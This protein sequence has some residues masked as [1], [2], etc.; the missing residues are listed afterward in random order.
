MDKE[1][2]Q[3]A[4]MNTLE[5]ETRCFFARDYACWQSYFI[6]EEYAFQAW[7]NADG[8][9]SAGVGWKA[10]DSTAGQ[11]IRDNPVGE[12]GSSHPVVKRRDMKFHFF[13]PT[14]A[15]LTWDQYNADPTISWYI[16]SKETRLMEK[17][18]A[19]WKIVNVTALWDASKKIPIDSIP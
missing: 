6:H 10:I 13:S 12:A 7:T 4:I 11:W 8:S 17:V 19:D 14:L 16:R 3:H 1:A 2:E 9:F 15:F 18:Q 5:N